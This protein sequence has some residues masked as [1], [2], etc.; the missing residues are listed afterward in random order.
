MLAW[1]S[2]LNQVSRGILTEQL[3]QE[4]LKSA[5]IANKNNNPQAKTTLARLEQNKPNPFSETTEINYTLPENAN[6]AKIV[7]YSLIID[8]Q[9]IDTK[10]MILTN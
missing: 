6:N 8:D 5:Q 7:L 10:R 9:E 4:I 1:L 2:G 3:N